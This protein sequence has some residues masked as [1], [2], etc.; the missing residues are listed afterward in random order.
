MTL[1]DEHPDRSPNAEASLA[2]VSED[3]GNKSASKN[4]KGKIQ[5]LMNM[6][7]S[8]RRDIAQAHSLAIYCKGTKKRR[9]F[10]FEREEKCRLWTSFLQERVQHSHVETKVSPRKAREKF[11]KACPLF[12][13][14]HVVLDSSALLTKEHVQILASRKLPK[15]CNLLLTPTLRWVFKFSLRSYSAAGS[16]LRN[17]I[18]DDCERAKAEMRKTPCKHFTMRTS[19]KLF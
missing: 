6:R 10:V 8:L 1:L 17:M 3:K 12:G 4:E 15:V 13:M 18:R 7:P 9:V 19:H 16:N 11:A 5:Q 2:E 14:S